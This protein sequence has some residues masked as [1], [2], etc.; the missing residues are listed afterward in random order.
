MEQRPSASTQAPGE[1]DSRE[2]STHAPV[3]AATTGRE[4]NGW[5]VDGINIFCTIGFAVGL[6]SFMVGTAIFMIGMS[7][8][9]ESFL[10]AGSVLYS[11]A[12]VSIGGRIA[13]RK[14]NPTNELQALAVILGSA[15]CAWLCY[16]LL[17][18][19]LGIL[20]FPA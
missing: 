16:E 7:M 13:L 20:G 15:L 5:E 3:S 14:L 8:A 1:P 18:W 4:D 2:S 10:T 9:N 11:L 17:Q 19:L 12:F 6:T